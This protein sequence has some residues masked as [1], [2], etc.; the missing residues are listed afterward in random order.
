MRWWRRR[1]RA[2]EL[3]VAGG[4]PDGTGGRAIFDAEWYR[5]HNP[6]DGT[7]TDFAPEQILHW[8]GENPH[9]QRLGLSPLETLRSVIAEDAAF[10]QAN[11]E[12]AKSGLQ[13]PIWV[14]RP[15]EAPEWSNEAR[16]RAEED[17]R[18]R[19]GRVNGQPLVFEEGMEV[20]RF[21]VSPKDAEA[22]DVRRWLKAEVAQPTATR[23]RWSASRATWRR[24]GS[25]LRRHA[26]ALLRGVHPDAE[27]PHSGAGV[28]A[29]RTSTSSSTWTRSRW[30]TSG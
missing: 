23:G 30:A 1:R 26:P 27:Q 13:E 16:E 29:R 12:L 21:G 14:Y 6:H 3:P 24:R 11:V 10:Q 25:V 22:L 17:M 19:L 2:V 20:R 8:R 28:L 4:A 9:D 18:N 15:L 5:Y 7:Y